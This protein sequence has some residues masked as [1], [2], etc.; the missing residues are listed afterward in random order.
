M[1]IGL[2]AGCNLMLPSSSPV[3]KV[4]KGIMDLEQWDFYK[5][6]N[7]RLNGEWAFYWNKHY[8]RQELSK[9]YISVPSTWT[10]KKGVP[11]QGHAAYQL[12][13]QHLKK[14]TEYALDIPSISTAYDLWVNGELL[15]SNGKPGPSKETT[16]P[17]YRPQKVNFFT[18]DTKA[19]IILH[20]SNYHYR[21]GGIWESIT[22]GTAEQI[23]DYSFKK[24]TIQ[25]IIFGGLLLSGLYHVVLFIQRRQ[26]KA[27]LYF[28]LVCLIVCIRIVVTK[29][30]PLVNFFPN[31]PW[32]LIVKLEYLSFYTSVP[33]FCW[34]LYTLYPAH[35]S[36]KFCKYFTALSIAFSLFVILNTTNIFTH[37]AIYYQ[38]V[39]IVT[40]IYMSVALL[41]ALKDKQEGSLI[42]T[43][44]VL[45]LSFTVINDILAANSMIQTY[46]LSSFGLFVFIFSQSYIIANR[47]SRAFNEMER[48]TTELEIL[49]QT[50]EEKVQERTTSL[51]KST[52][53]LQNL[54]SQLKNLSYIDQLTQIPNRRYF[55][56][57]FEQQWNFAIEN[58][59]SLAVIY[60][61]IDYFK[62]YNDMYGHE[63]GDQCLQ[64]VARA[65][66]DT[67]KSYGGFVARLGG[68]E[69][70]AVLDDINTDYLQTVCE[71]CRRDIEL[72]K[73]RHEG[74][75]LC[76]Q[77]TI[78]I[79]AALIM[80]DKTMKRRDLIHAADDALYKAKDNGRNQVY[81]TD[82][83]GIL[84]SNSK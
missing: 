3:V 73:I 50:L 55:D 44:C 40:I 18:K 82:E 22:F 45:F 20:V 32:V 31:I 2:L 61:D 76:Q 51:E 37:S 29:D 11:G 46:H 34:V 1:L 72:L 35:I 16:T 14:N 27:A 7:I 26:N 36:K 28:S 48:M 8:P 84:F 67:F 24:L 17:F 74:S 47:S 10:S 6:G 80:P 54:N 63:A 58:R 19:E 81:V 4:D 66:Q 83:K 5:D 68:E 78:S 70:V 65:L 56:E 43:L 69:F 64:E 9:Q 13:I 75:L 71:S 38:I 60:M 62:R 30:I 59:G 49:N 79:G 39:T 57:I 12:T 42:V 25:M 77:I 23:K 21:D 41:R 53:E 33:L 15:A 52:A